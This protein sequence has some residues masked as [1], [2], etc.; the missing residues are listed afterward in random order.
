MIWR[1]EKTQKRWNWVKFYLSQ[2][3]STLHQQSENSMG[4]R[5]DTILHWIG[6]EIMQR[7]KGSSFSHVSGDCCTARKVASK[8]T[9]PA[10]S[11]VKLFWARNR[12]KWVKCF[13]LFSWLIQDA[14]ERCDMKMLFHVEFYEPESIAKKRNFH[15]LFENL[16]E[17][18]ESWHDVTVHRRVSGTAKVILFNIKNIN[19]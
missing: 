19:T 15:S 14:G 6:W 13:I 3:S 1:R 12:F 17:M 2:C 10:K 9:K 11:S 5:I 16:L 8:S 7:R 18:L 4:F